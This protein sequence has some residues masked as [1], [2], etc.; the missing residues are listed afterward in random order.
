MKI[1][2]NIVWI[3]FGGLALFFSW[4]IVGIFLCITIIG[5]PFGIQCFKYA[6]LSLAPFGKKVK[7]DYFDHPIVNTIWVFL[8]GWE[9]FLV[10][11]LAGLVCCLSIVGIPVGIQ[12][13]KF[14]VLSLAP[15]GADVKKSKK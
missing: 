4:L 10:Q 15:F 12:A 13:F 11:M 7:L 1:V 6:K 8:F 3:L 9:L 14:S 5:F 2:A